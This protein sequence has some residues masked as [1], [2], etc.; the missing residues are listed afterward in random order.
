MLLEKDFHS[1]LTRKLSVNVNG[2]GLIT[3][4]RSQ[5]RGNHLAPGAIRSLV[6]GYICLR[7]QM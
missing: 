7:S 5:Y 6:P 4:G 3:R 1:I 2:L